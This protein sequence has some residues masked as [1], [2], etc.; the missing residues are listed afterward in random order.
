MKW[1]IDKEDAHVS[2]GYLIPDTKDAREVINKLGAK[3]IQVCGDRFEAKDRPHVPERTKPTP[4][5]HRAQSANIKKAQ[6]AR[7]K[8]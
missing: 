1:L 5:Q 2:N 8:K 3:P 4:A 7:R 6:A